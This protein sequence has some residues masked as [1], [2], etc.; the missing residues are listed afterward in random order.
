MSPGVRCASWCLGSRDRK[1]YFPAIWV[2]QEPQTH[3]AHG[4]LLPPETGGPCWNHLHHVLLFPPHLIHQN[5]EWRHRSPGSCCL[6]WASKAPK[7]PWA[8]AELV[9]TLLTPTQGRTC[10]PGPREQHCLCPGSPKVFPGRDPC[11][12][13][14]DSSLLGAQKAEESQGWREWKPRPGPVGTWPMTHTCT[15]TPPPGDPWVVPSVSSQQNVASAKAR[16]S[17]HCAHCACSTQ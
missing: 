2:W 14:S 9:R 17:A 11:I 13:G 12:F 15:H 3:L 7:S 16:N 5:V 6:P 1:I 10:Y 4:F 8:H